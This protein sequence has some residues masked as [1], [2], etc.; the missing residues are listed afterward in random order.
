VP[1]GISPWNVIR[2]VTL[3]SVA[4][5][6]A[7]N[8]AVPRLPKEM[9]SLPQWLTSGIWHLVPLSLLVIL[10]VVNPIAFFISRR[11]PRLLLEILTPIDGSEVDLMRTVRG[12]VTIAGA[13]VQLLVYA[14]DNRWYPQRRA[15][16]DGRAWNAECQ[17]GNPQ[18]GAGEHFRVVAISTSSPIR[19]PTE[20]LPKRCV[21]SQIVNV[22]RQ[23][24]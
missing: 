18:S 22:V 17:F 7:L 16:I 23:A 4:V 19:N 8:E 24:Q 10:L 6:E 15:T 20:N 11:R 14:G 2:Y 12:A 5:I 1:V 13:P 9:I 3:V 21:K